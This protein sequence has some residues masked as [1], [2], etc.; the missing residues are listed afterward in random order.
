[1]LDS[2]LASL[3]NCSAQYD[4]FYTGL[5]ADERVV[6]ALIDVLKTPRCD[7]SPHDRTG[8]LKQPDQTRP[9]LELKPALTFV[10]IG[11]DDGEVVRLRVPR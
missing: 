3:S 9:I 2:M 7:Q 5:F 10:A 11:P 8:V 4:T 1:M 6:S